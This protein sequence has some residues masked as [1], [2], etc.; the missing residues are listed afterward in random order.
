MIKSV[1]KSQL[2]NEAD[3]TINEAELSANFICSL[4]NTFPTQFKNLI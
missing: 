4:K 1:K 3:E 2:N